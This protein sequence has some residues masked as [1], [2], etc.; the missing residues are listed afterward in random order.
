MTDSLYRTQAA[1]CRTEAE[2]ATLGNVRERCLRAEAAWLGMA[3]RSERVAAEQLLRRNET[4]N[5]KNDLP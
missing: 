3:A 4:L 5:R 2:Q 1:K